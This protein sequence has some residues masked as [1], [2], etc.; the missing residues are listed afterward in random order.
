L[1]SNEQQLKRGGASMS[2]ALEQYLPHWNAEQL[3]Q[4][5][6]D[7]PEMLTELVDLYTNTFPEQ[8]A[9]LSVAL[10]AKHSADSTLY[11]HDIKGS[12][13]NMGAK[14][15]RTTAA[16]MEALAKQE[17]FTEAAALL[18][19]LHSNF[20][21]FSTVLRGYVKRIHAEGEKEEDDES[22]DESEEDQENLASS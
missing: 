9:K 11:A 18:P 21:S 13:A 7:M 6:G 10:E 2:D 22:D 15:V 8:E 3:L 17:Q 14:S 1:Y 4:V 12:S 16:A 5:C 19:E 20:E